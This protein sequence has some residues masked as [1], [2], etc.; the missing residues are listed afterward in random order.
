MD[1]LKLNKEL[2]KAVLDENFERVAYL[3][4]NGA[5]ATYRVNTDAGNLL[6]HTNNVQIASLL[7][8][9]GAKINARNRY[10]KT[11]LHIAVENNNSELVSLLLKNGASMSDVEVI[12]KKNAL[13]VAI[14][15]NNLTIVKL[16][17][18]SGCNIHE[19][20]NMFLD[21]TLH[22]ALRTALNGFFGN[23]EMILYLLEKGADPTV[24][25]SDKHYPI[26]L[27]LKNKNCS[28]SMISK[29][30]KYGADIDCKDSVGN[31]PLH[32]VVGTFS[33]VD[34]LRVVLKHSPILNSFNNDGLNPLHVALC[35]CA[36]PDIIRLLLSYSDSTN[37]YDIN[38]FQD[39][40]PVVL[41][42]SF[43]SGK[44]VNV[45]DKLLNSPLYI[46]VGKIKYLSIDVIEELLQHGYHPLEN[47]TGAKNN[48]TIMN[49]VFKLLVEYAVINHNVEEF[50][51]ID[52]FENSIEA[53]INL[54]QTEISLLEKELGLSLL[55]L[56]NLRSTNSSLPTALLNQ[57]IEIATGY[58]FP[59]YKPFIR[60]Q[61]KRSE[62]LNMLLKQKI[63][64][65]DRNQQ[66]TVCLDWASVSH[67]AKYLTNLDLLNLTATYYKFTSISSKFKI[68]KNNKFNQHLLCNPCNYDNKRLIMCSEDDISMR[69]NYFYGKQQIKHFDL[70][71]VPLNDKFVGIEGMAQCTNLNVIDGCQCSL[72]LNA[73]QECKSVEIVECLLKLGA[74]IF[75]VT[76]KSFDNALHIALQG[77]HS[78]TLIIMR[79][80]L[81]YGSKANICNYAKKAKF[82]PVEIVKSLKS[83]LFVNIVN[84]NGDT[85]MHL[86]LQH[87]LNNS[88]KDII[89]E[90]LL[91]GGDL[92][93]MNNLGRNP[94]FYFAARVQEIP[95]H[96]INQ[97][98]IAKKLM[99]V[100]IK[101]SAIKNN[102]DS[103][104]FSPLHLF[105]KDSYIC[106]WT[107]DCKHELSLLEK[108]TVS[109]S[110]ILNTKTC[111]DKCV[112]SHMLD[113]IFEI[114]DR[115]EY[116]IYEELLVSKISKSDLLK[117]LTKLV[118]NKLP[119][120]RKTNFAILSILPYITQYLN[121]QDLLTWVI[122]FAVQSSLKAPL[123]KC[124]SLKRSICDSSSNGNYI[125]PIKAI[126]F[127]NE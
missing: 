56:S 44:F 7:I 41:I 121:K 28:P 50:L 71:C 92:T 54:C 19:P 22:L 63:L 26:H 45:C 126:K 116:P 115:H 100:F 114:C 6:H 36:E 33:N 120:Q 98:D 124:T 43:R 82:L 18:E 67:L 9:K 80:L 127:S 113:R 72:L 52:L 4:E 118:L 99:K 107:L 59:I 108:E 2:K 8:D 111:E 86:V 76:E 15:N 81:R 79:I 13:S 32:Y 69:N 65:N 117:R 31:T 68:N 95:P 64:V 12:C 25:D 53:Y 60:A 105:F 102:F 104:M 47:E 24:P 48:D 23:N 58:K 29:L 93:M 61:F 90:L 55:E 106:N 27:A 96:E 21:N 84:A 46:A 125:V 77:I 112:L 10:R 88:I 73:I 110:Y 14:S 34:L 1:V 103:Q 78:N 39:C 91:Y 101:F 57:M 123:L 97:M 35:H 83:R 87:S 20:M 3:L 30:V 11:P 37:V 49:D 38:Y 122:A 85:P 75:T 74:D 5:N 62:L 70:L 94:I 109:D 42:N 17:V 51:D 16:L 66:K 89:I 40:V 119:Y